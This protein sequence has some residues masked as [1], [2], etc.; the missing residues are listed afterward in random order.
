MNSPRL[1]FLTVILFAGMQAGFQRASI[2]ADD[3]FQQSVLPVL[4]KHCLRCHGTETQEGNLR[5]DQLNPD[6][7]RGDDADRWH[8]VLNRVNVGEMPP[9]DEP[10]LSEQELTS[11]TDWLTKKLQEAATARRSGGGQIHLRRLNR[12]EYGNTM[13]DLLGSLGS[14]PMTPTQLSRCFVRSKSI[15]NLTKTSLQQSPSF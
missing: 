14:I 3:E 4:R 7:V 10:A 5:I 12:R 15:V 9:E 1:C 6:I 13:R 2:A 8:E 11:L